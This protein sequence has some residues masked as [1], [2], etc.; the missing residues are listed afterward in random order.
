VGS[1]YSANGSF[2]RCFFNDTISTVTS[3]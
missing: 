2:V 3:I 1:A